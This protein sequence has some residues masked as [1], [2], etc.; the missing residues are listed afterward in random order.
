ME[1]RYAAHSGNQSV[2]P[3]IAER[4]VLDYRLKAIVYRLIPM[5][6]V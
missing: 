6:S 3:A 2:M 5:E 1:D 4:E